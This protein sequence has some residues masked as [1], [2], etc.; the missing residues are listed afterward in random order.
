MMVT[1]KDIGKTA[2]VNIKGHTFKAKIHNIIIYQGG[3]ETVSIETIYNNIIELS[4]NAI[5]SIL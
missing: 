1:A 2:M 5:K 3:T 4:M